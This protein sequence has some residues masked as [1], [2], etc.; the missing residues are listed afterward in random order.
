LVPKIISFVLNVVARYC[1]TTAV[2]RSV[3][4]DRRVSAFRGSFVERAP[5]GGVAFTDKVYV[6]NHRQIG[7]QIDANVPKGAFKGATLDLLFNGE[8]LEKLDETTR[9]RVLEFA[10]DFLDCD[11][12]DNPY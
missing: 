2:L 6:K 1:G 5:R 4:L 10:E 9:D 3:G 11:C 8:N 7:S 12:R